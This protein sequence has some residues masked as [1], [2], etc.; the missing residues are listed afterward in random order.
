MIPLLGNMGSVEAGGVGAA[1][2]GG[3]LELLPGGPP[4]APGLPAAPPAT[5]G[6]PF[7]IEFDAPGTLGALTIGGRPLPSLEEDSPAHAAQTSMHCKLR[8]TASTLDG[9]DVMNHLVRP[10]RLPDLVVRG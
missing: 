10:A 2:A 1:S 8:A 6:E 5:T 7:N 9:I 4:E 3:M